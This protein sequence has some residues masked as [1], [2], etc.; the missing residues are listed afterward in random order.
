MKSSPCEGRSS[1][2]G[3]VAH[4]FR[5]PLATAL[6]CAQLLGRLAPEERAGAR[7]LKLAATAQRA[8]VRVGRLLEDHFLAERIEA[9]GF[10]LRPEPVELAAAARAAGEAAGLGALAAYAVPEGLVL[11]ADRPLLARCLE[12]AMAAAGREGAMVRVEAEP[13]D[14]GAIVRIAGAPLA[15]EALQQPGK[16]SPSDPAGRSLGLFAAGAAAEA[17]GG[18]L[19]VEGGAAVLTFPGRGS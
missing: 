6:W 5:N 7:G 19:A 10:P 12:A 17:M 18:S 2:L 11:Q 15:P 13:R 3:F 1:Y 8:M 4:E 16:G 14:G 9:G